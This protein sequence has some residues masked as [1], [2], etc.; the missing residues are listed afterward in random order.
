MRKGSYFFMSLSI[1]L[2]VWLSF[3]LKGLGTFFALLYAF[4]II[5]AVEL[6]LSPMKENPSQEEVQSLAQDPLYDY[7]IWLMVP[8]Q[9]FLL[10]SFV[11]QVPERE[12]LE[13]LGVTLSFGAACGSLAINCA[14]ELGHRRSHFEQFLSKALLL[15]SLYLHF[16]I[17]HNKGH[18]RRVGTPEDP[19]TSR[20]NESVYFFWFR[21]IVYSFSSSFQID[22][23][24]TSL[25]VFVQVV[26]VACLGFFISLKVMLAFLFSAAFGIILL[27][28]VNYIEHY[29][30]QRKKLA[31]GKYEKVQIHHSWNSDHPLGRAVL[32]E[33]SRHSDHHALA[34]KKYQCL[35]SHKES[36]QLPAGYPAMMLL[37]L[38]PPLWFHVMNPRVMAYQ[39][40]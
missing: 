13:L 5:P 19:A 24:M 8:I 9:Y 38:V 15:T 2:S 34:S 25:Y 7:I 29:G 21:S 40:S 11:R 1:P 30:L 39:E 31:N 14:H 35:E 33:L 32:F 22:S 4:V 16:F 23:K 10:I 6:F 37:S 18:H 12:G 3:Q 27:E 28:T 17:E 26:F 20:L 36:P